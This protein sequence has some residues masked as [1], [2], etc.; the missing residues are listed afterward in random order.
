MVQE[1]T[2]LEGKWVLT[3]DE[4]TIPRNKKIFAPANLRA[5]VE[6][7]A[8]H[9]LIIGWMTDQYTLRY[10]GGLVPDV[11]HIFAKVIHTYK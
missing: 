8:Y 11:Y 2:L 1:L 3:K 6:N 5:S 7:S 9:K 4:M 10:S